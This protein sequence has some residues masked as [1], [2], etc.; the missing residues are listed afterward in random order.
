MHAVRGGPLLQPCAQRQQV[1]DVGGG[2]AE[3]VLRQFGGEP[4]GALFHLGD[5]DAEV[6]PQD[7]LEAVLIVGLGALF[8]NA[9]SGHATLDALPK[10]LRTLP[11]GVAWTEKT[12]VEG[13]LEHT[14][15]LTGRVADWVDKQAAEE[16][17]PEAALSR[18]PGAKPP[19]TAALRAFAKAYSEELRA[20]RGAVSRT[21]RRIKVDRSTAHRWKTRCDN[22][23]LLPPRE[24]NLR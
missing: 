1:R 5:R 18:G 17:T 9:R 14:H 16:T 4:V 22:Q 12:H 6:A 2:V 19:T 20:G 8:S 21:A 3:L 13:R 23:G 15:T 10:R 11:D 7:G 24:S